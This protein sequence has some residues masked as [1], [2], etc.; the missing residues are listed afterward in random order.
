[1]SRR[2]LTL[3]L[4]EAKVY[5]RKACEHPYSMNAYRAL[6][7]S[8]HRCK[9]VAKQAY[10]TNDERLIVYMIDK[11]MSVPSD[12][13]K[14]FAYIISEG[15]EVTTRKFDVDNITQLRTCVRDL[16]QA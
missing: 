12:T 10:I 15:G 7:G 11:D 6:W 2:R 14:G 9:N 5:H 1:M 3:P 13:V 4:N 8:V 16:A